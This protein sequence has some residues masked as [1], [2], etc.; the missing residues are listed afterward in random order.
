L[1]AVDRRCPAHDLGAAARTE[2]CE[3]AACEGFRR[4]AKGARENEAGEFLD[5]NLA[6][7]KQALREVEKI[8]TRISNERSRSRPRPA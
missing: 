4:M 2:A 7:E 3:I 5:E 1:L 6:Q 8:A